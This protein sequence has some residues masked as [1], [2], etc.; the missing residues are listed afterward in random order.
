VKEAEAEAEA[1]AEL[2]LLPAEVLAAVLQPELPPVQVRNFFA[3][4]IPQSVP[5]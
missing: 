4:L 5:E 3:G 1:E 2:P